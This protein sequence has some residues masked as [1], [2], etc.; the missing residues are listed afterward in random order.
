[1]ADPVFIKHISFVPETSDLIHK[2]RL[3]INN[4]KQSLRPEFPLQNTDTFSY[5][6]PWVVTTSI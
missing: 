4:G 5:S 6:I 3:L 2:M 1:V